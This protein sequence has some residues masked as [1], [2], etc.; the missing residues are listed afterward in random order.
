VRRAI[1]PMALSAV[2]GAGCGSSA[3]TPRSETGAKPA[4]RAPGSRLT[5]QTTPKF[6]AP[7]SGEP[8]RSGVVRIT[9]RYFTIDPDTVRVRAGSTLEWSNTDPGPDNVTSVSGPQRFASP[10]LAEG[11]TF[12]LR[13]T[14]PGIY[15]Y[16]STRHPATM[17][18]TI[19]V[20]R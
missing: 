18:G 5:L 17:N 13:L 4:A 3:S 14:R 8:V 9:Y 12:T 6:A 20:L 11:D 1:I 10:S 19:E 15:H 2:L 16:E 7:A